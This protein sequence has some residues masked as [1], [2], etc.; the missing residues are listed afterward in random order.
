MEPSTLTTAEAIVIDG[1]NGVT[2]APREHFPQLG[3]SVALAV[4]AVVIGLFLVRRRAR[5]A[6]LVVLALAAVPGLVQVLALRADAPVSRVELGRTIAT[7]LADLQQHAPWPVHPVAVVREDD[8]VMFPLTRYAV[9]A[10]LE[11]PPAG[12]IEL[13]TRGARLGVRCRV[14]G[15][16]NIC[17][18]GP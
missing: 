6:L 18:D 7:T 1:A 9:P 8:D 12:A 15:A 14:E 5:G 11:A 17:G 10:R 2:R 3:L 13:E 4:A 16:R